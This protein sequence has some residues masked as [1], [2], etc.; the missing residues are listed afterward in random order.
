MKVEQQA[1][2][3]KQLHGDGE[4]LM[5]PDGKIDLPMWLAAMLLHLSGIRSKK[6][7]VQKKVIK[8]EVIGLL[9]RA[10]AGSK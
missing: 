3:F 5:H 8:R 7:R 1:E 6:K 9:R 10:A 4:F 2:K